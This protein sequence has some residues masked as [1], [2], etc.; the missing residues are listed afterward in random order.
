MSSTSL[1]FLKNL[2]E[3]S[4][5]FYFVAPEDSSVM[6]FNE[7]IETINSNVYIDLVINTDALNVFDKKISNV[8]VNFGRAADE[9][10]ILFFFDL[11][12]L[13]TLS[14]KAGLDYLKTW[15]IDF[16]TKYSL[17]Y[18]ICQL[19]NGD[20]DEYYFDSFGTGKLYDNVS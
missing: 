19:D 2:I 16:K 8:F 17:D 15:A 14:N 4:E 13:N 10:E 20:K 18:F 11:R 3:E 6:S 12:D 1:V 5:R 9:T 7:V